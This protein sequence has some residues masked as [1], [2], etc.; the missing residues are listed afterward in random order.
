M[1]LLRA[2][3]SPNVTLIP[4]KSLKYCK[5]VKESLDLQFSRIY[6]TKEYEGT[7]SNAQHQDTY[8][9]SKIMCHPDMGHFQSKYYHANTEL[10]NLS[11]PIHLFHSNFIATQPTKF[12]ISEIPPTNTAI[13]FGHESYLVTFN[14]QQWFRVYSPSAY[15]S[16]ICRST[17]FDMYGNP[18]AN[19]SRVKFSGK[20]TT[21]Q[22]IISLFK[23][24]DR[25]TLLCDFVFCNRESS[26][27][28]TTIVNHYT[29]PIVLSMYAG[30]QE[31]ATINLGD[32][33][34]GPVLAR[35]AKIPPTSW[36]DRCQYTLEVAAGADTV[37]M[38]MS[39]LAMVQFKEYIIAQ[40]EI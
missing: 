3:N 24:G 25:S 6:R 40:A 37:L 13:R 32:Y 31:Y 15:E 9:C 8:Q 26:I 33:E 20:F 11:F 10:A 36:F 39:C 21:N 19:L 12:I 16:R 23:G 7:M 1:S 29:N 35:S 38:L 2:T 34:T 30:F 17:L 22:F 28:C 27:T 4:L 14:G 18:I 5:L